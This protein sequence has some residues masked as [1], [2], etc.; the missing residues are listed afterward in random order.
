MSS[1]GT[2][3]IHD[4]KGVKLVQDDILNMARL[5]AACKG[6]EA[7]YHLAAQ[8][9][10]PYSMQQPP[11]DFD[12][13]LKGTLNV[14]EAAVRVG[15]RLFFASSAA[16][17]GVPNAR[18]IPESHVRAPISFYGLSKKSAEL[19]CNMYS[20]TFQLPVT[21]FRIFNAYG[22]HCHGVIHDILG[23]LVEDPGQLQVLGKPTGSKDFIYI[24]DVIDAIV[25]PLEDDQAEEVEIFNV[26][27]GTCTTIAS[28]IFNICDILSAKPLTY[29]TGSSWIGDVAQGL[30]ADTSK[31]S[32][33]FGWKPRVSLR[34]GLGKT[35]E[36]FRSTRPD[37]LSLK[38]EV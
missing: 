6:A 25:A 34:E 38:V 19:Y 14:L 31:L 27:S 26:G 12:V 20:D 28:L 17:Y 30:C 8:V 2:E 16:V 7:I 5:M 33:R 11:A 24:S 29:F 37:R 13:N 10:V 3:R 9:S 23:R 22:P 36:W 1:A 21:I 18:P 32:A 35:V 15:A 4:L